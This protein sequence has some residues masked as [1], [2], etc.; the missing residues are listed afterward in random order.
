[1]DKILL[2]GGAG[3]IGSHIAVAL[4]GEGYLPIVVD[5][6]SNS[7]DETKRGLQTLIPEICFYE[8]NVAEAGKLKKVFQT[9]KPS[10]IIH[11]AAY[12]YVDRSIQ[13]PLSYYQNNLASLINVL[14]LALEHGLKTFV[15]SSS[16][17]VYGS[18]GK[19]P[20]S[21][22]DPSGNLIS[23]YAQS[24]QMGEQI[25]WDSSVASSCL[26][27]I[28]LRYFNPVGAHPSVEIG[29]NPLIKPS[30][31]VPAM[32]EAAYSQRP[33]TVYGHDYDTPD[34]TCIRDYIHVMDLAEAHVAALKWGM[35]KTQSSYEIFNCGTGKGTSVQELREVFQDINQVKVPVRQGSRR[36][37]DIPALYASTRKIEEQMGW[38]AR[39]SLSDALKTAWCW[40]KKLRSL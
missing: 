7:S 10:G 15:F 21:E 23:P 1:M 5:D 2:T 18:V 29:E 31:I 24:K 39:R 27:G 17:A 3:Y 20:V 35:K 26:S 25:L 22:E 8:M 32:M 33:M 16:C 6:F 9:E 11:L 28:S 14:S 19:I 40:E 34:G 37:G 30:N 12:K 13:E 36:P 38:K 4:A